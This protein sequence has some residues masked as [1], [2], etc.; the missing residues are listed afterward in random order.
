MGL[1]ENLLKKTVQN[2]ERASRLL[3]KHGHGDS[4]KQPDLENTQIKLM[5][6]LKNMR[7]VEGKLE[8]GRL[9]IFSDGLFL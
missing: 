4:E 8:Q 6:S 1:L 9:N 3:D 5:K 2:N 7:S